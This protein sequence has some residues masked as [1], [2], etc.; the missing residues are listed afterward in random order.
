MFDEVPD[1]AIRGERGVDLFQRRDDPA[2][3]RA[4]YRCIATLG[5]AGLADH[6]PGARRDPARLIALA[7]G[8]ANAPLAAPV[9]LVDA[10]T[11]GGLSRPGAS[12]AVFLH[13][14]FLRAWQV[15]ELAAARFEEA[16]ARDPASQIADP[17]RLAGA[18]GALYDFN[19]L[20][21]A[22]RLA[23]LLLGPLAMRTAAPGFR[24]D[25]PGNTGYALRML[26][27]LALRNDQP[28]LA[29]R[30][31]ETAIGAGDN[32]HRRRR[33]IEAARAA[34]DAEAL[35]RHRAAYA[36]RWPLPPD[37]AAPPPGPA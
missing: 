33:A 24:D 34:D 35:A 16:C 3:K 1:F 6:D 13:L 26:G 37:L 7:E 19:R 12:L 18:V 9:S 29:L 23:R 15:A 8:L 25:G 5:Q 21:R 30:C 32:S 17:A 10:T 4:I 36:S 14:D 31:F 28:A 2:Q 11:W 27:D 20:G 22:D